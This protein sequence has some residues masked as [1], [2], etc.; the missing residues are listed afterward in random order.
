MFVVIHNVNNHE[1]I[2]RLELSIRI[3]YM[4]WLQL[5]GSFKL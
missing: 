1:H 3:V 4:E 2:L 5:V